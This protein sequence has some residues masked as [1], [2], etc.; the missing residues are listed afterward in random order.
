MPSLF[1][2]QHYLSSPS[3]SSLAILSRF[4]LKKENAIIN[5][6][7]LVQNQL[8][9]KVMSYRGE[10]GVRGTT[11]Y[12]KQ[13]M[14]NGRISGAAREFLSALQIISYTRFSS[15]LRH[16]AITTF[17]V[18]RVPVSRVWLHCLSMGGDIGKR[19]KWQQGS[20]NMICPIYF[21]DS[22]KS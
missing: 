22:E 8:H 17:W 2:Y 21:S 14:Y 16:K 1:S 3:E 7:I 11:T 15:S 18:L 20:R 12:S 13:W 6:F 5:E 19:K 10:V 4:L 9:W